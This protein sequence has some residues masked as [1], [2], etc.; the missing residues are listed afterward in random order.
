M[1][2]TASLVAA[3]RAIL[4]VSRRLSV[5]AICGCLLLLAVPAH[6]ALNE[7]DLQVLA[8]TLGFLDP[9]LGG[10][11]NIGIVY[12]PAST[13]STLDATAARDLLAAGLRVGNTVL[14]G[15]LV[16]VAQAAAAEVDLFLLAGGS[17][18]R[19]AELVPVLQQRQLACISA[20]L[21]QVRAGHCAVG[22]QSAPR[23]EIVVNSELAGE[24]GMSFASVFRMMVKEL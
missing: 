15:T 17:G 19:A 18:A 13:A 20:D 16:P 7:R 1:R 6:A 5:A 23:V 2:S 8:R 4:R 14:H 11:L 21:E 3:P 24:C 10:E 12:D 9:P 22:I